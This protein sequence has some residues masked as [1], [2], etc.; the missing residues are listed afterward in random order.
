MLTKHEPVR[1]CDCYTIVLAHRMVEGGRQMDVR[2]P[3]EG[4]TI[5]AQ[6]GER[7]QFSGSWRASVFPTKWY[8]V[9]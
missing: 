3:P 5:T 4:V 2:W 6:P 9:A 7:E 1:L 8:L